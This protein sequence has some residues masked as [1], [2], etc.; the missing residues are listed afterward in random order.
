MPNPL[1][2]AFY[3]RPGDRQNGKNNPF[4]RWIISQFA[5]RF[6]RTA[7][8]RTNR[9]Q[10]PKCSMKLRFEIYRRRLADELVQC[11]PGR[12]SARVGRW[13]S[14]PF[15]SGSDTTVFIHFAFAAKLFNWT[16]IPQQ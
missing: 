2:G 3:A 5:I 7:T 9:A 8:F 14:Y 10:V 12:E 11:Q 4:N 16:L 13:K 6:A 1:R 15:T